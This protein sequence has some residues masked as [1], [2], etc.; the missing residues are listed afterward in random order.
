[1][2][3]KAV[4]SAF[5]VLLVFIAYIPYFRDIFR[6]KTIPHTFTWLVWTLAVGVTCA[7]QIAGGAGVGAWMTAALALVCFLI[8]LLSFWKGTKDITK[9]DVLFLALALTALVLWLFAEQPV[10]SVI[11]IVATD[12]FGLAPTV[13]KSWHDPYSETLV[14][15][16]ITTFRHALSIFALEQINIL[17]VLYPIVWVA[18]N[19]AFSALLMYRRKLVPRNT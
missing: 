6:N 19:G 10:L 11:L 18:A 13:R 5:V 7:L 8:F 12:V 15:Y 16:Q 9:L 3:Y 17:T 4:I 2:E 14:M 1:M